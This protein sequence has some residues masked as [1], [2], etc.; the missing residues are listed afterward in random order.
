M[1][2]GI[3]GDV[4]RSGHARIRLRDLKL[5]ASALDGTPDSVTGLLVVPIKTRQEPK[6]IPLFAALL[7]F[8]PAVLGYSYDP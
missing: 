5:T 8:G 4:D 1:P 7:V 6:P 2:P 3:A